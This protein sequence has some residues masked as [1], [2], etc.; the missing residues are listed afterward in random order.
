MSRVRTR[1]EPEHPQP[2]EER[3]DRPAASTGKHR[4]AISGRFVKQST[5]NEDERVLALVE[6]VV[7]AI[8]R[9]VADALAES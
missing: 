4:S 6:R 9:A 7:A 5:D 1:A 2:A 8:P 3:D